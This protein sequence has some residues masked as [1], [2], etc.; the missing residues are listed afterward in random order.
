MGLHSTKKHKPVLLYANGAFAG[1]LNPKAVFS[2]QPCYLRNWFL[3]LL[4]TFVLS[5]RSGFQVVIAQQIKL[6]SN[7]MKRTALKKKIFF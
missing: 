7:R 6:H 3:L 1:T 2:D 4:Y 5:P